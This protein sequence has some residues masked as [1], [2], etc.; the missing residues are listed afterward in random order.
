MRQYSSFFIA[1]FKVEIRKPKKNERKVLTI[2]PNH[3]NISKLSRA[4]AAQPSGLKK[5]QKV[6]DKL[7]LA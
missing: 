4:T 6:L 2:T 7:A 3:G 5:N 1:I